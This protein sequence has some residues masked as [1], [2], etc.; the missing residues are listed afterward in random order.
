MLIY[1]ILDNFIIDSP[2]NTVFEFCLNGHDR[3]K[4][5]QMSPLILM[6]MVPVQLSA[7]V[8][9][10]YYIKTYK[11]IRTHLRPEPEVD[12]DTHQN[13]RRA[14]GRKA[15]NNTNMIMAKALQ[16]PLKATVISGGTVLGSLSFTVLMSFFNNDDTI[17]A[18]FF[19]YITILT[20]AI[21]NP[22]ISTL[23]FKSNEVNRYDATVNECH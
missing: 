8:T 13:A 2:S 12:L 6:V 3:K 16:I 20:G 10:G 1:W 19:W 15:N 17:K 9:V 5:Q 21:R 11:F 22:L 23:V 14:L 18:K 7:V 4:L